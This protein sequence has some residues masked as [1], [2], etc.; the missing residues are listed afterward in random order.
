MINPCKCGGDSCLV[1]VRVTGL[2]N[3]FISIDGGDLGME[4]DTLK[5]RYQATVYC[6]DC[7]KRRSDLRY[8]NG[9]KEV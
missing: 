3:H 6:A 8:N 5:Y 4:T 2:A 7:G 9:L 1:K